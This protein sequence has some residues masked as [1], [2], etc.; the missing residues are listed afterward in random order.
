MTLYKLGRYEDAVEVYNITLELKETAE[1][2]DNLGL[3]YQELGLKK[4]AQSCFREAKA[5]RG[6]S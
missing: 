4:K 1:A 5:M 2:W 6:E 3:A